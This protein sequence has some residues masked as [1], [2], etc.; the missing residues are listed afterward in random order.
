MIGI[1][2]WGGLGNQMF[3]YA[4]GLYI[5]YKR[6]EIPLFYGEVKRNQGLKLNYFN[7][8]IDF[9]SLDIQRKNGY[10]SRYFILYRFKRKLI[11][12]FPLFNNRMLVEDN[13]N[14]KKT[15][16]NNYVLFDGYWQ[17]YKYLIPIEEKLRKDFTFNK[18]IISNLELY[19]EI[20]NNNSISIHIRKGDYLKGRNAKIYENIPLEYYQQA[21]AHFTIKVNSPVYYV[22]SNDLVWV[23]EYLNFP[24]GS[25]FIFV[26]NS[27]SENST[28]TDLYLMSSCKHH[29]IA[30][31][32]FSWW[33]AWLNPSKEKI[34]I[35][36]KKW[37]V[38]K[39][40]DSTIDLI[41]SEW[42]RF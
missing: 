33:G 34:V 26:D 8:T 42:E 20:I 25:K 18:S 3:Q 14:Y 16:S 10:N 38:G 36:P 5:S 9:L 7:V 4:F 24:I 1:K 13:L 30:N 2:L 40:N 27:K 11:Q 35:A 22:F 21:I 6:E 12:L 19:D 31:S 15:I 41:P 23:K 39:K 37:Y 17:S 29:V 28:I 32:T